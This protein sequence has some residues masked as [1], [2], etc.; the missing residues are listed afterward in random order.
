VRFEI[1]G[2]SSA[3]H[4]LRFEDYDTLA[5]VS[6]CIA[7]W[8]HP[9][10]ARARNRWLNDARERF[11]NMHVSLEEL[12]RLSTIMALDRFERLT[13]R[14]ERWAP[15]YDSPPIIWG[16]RADRPEHSD[17]FNTEPVL[18]TEAPTGRD[19]ARH[20]WS[21]AV[22]PSLRDLLNEAHAALA[23]HLDDTTS[24]DAVRAPVEAIRAV[25]AERRRRRPSRR[26]R[27]G[28]PTVLT[29]EQLA[30]YLNRDPY[31]KRR[32]ARQ[33]AKVI[34]EKSGKPVSEKTVRSRRKDLRKN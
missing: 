8:R 27:G 26:P 5:R 29:A 6:R 16:L 25:I 22:A 31:L 18:P 30:E 20:W 10:S 34:S 24:W 21:H 7:A 3:G 19:I 9:S 32:S 2:S 33:I 12:D 1:V 23:H 15:L 11:P 4:W 28:R 17:P 14:L 13:A